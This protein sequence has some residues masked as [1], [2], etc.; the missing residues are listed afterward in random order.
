[1]AP[2]VAGPTPGTVQAARLDLLLARRPEARGQLFDPTAE[3]VDLIKIEPSDLLDRVG[4]L[5][6]FAI[7]QQADDLPQVHRSFGDDDTELRQMATQ[8]V[9]QLD[10][11]KNLVI[12]AKA[13]VAPGARAKIGVCGV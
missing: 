3:H 1:M 4:N 9:D 8:G 5:L 10:T 13:A 2:A 7:L 12:L 6:R 11:R